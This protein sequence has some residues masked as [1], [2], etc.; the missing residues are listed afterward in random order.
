M[1]KKNQTIP[2]YVPEKLLHFLP[3]VHLQFR[4]R[5]KEKNVR[6]KLI[7]EKTKYMKE[8]KKK[9]KQELRTTKFYDSIMKNTESALFILPESILIIRANEKEQLG[10]YIQDKL[11]AQLQRK[12]FEVLWKQAKP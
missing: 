10:I 12:N 5:R 6:I 9:D 11:A 4:R 2:C 7:T 1:K 8:I 3:T